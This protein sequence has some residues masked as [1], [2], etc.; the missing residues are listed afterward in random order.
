MAGEWLNWQEFQAGVAPQA[1][2]QARQEAERDSA[3]LARYNQGVSGAE[4]AATSVG[5]KPVTS[6]AAYQDAQNAYKT[7]AQE[8]MHRAVAAPGWDTGSAGTT[9]M[10]SEWGKLAGRLA[11]A[12]EN[13]DGRIAAR[14][15]A[16]DEAFKRRQAAAASPIQA[17][18]DPK[19][20]QTVAAIRNRNTN[21][22]GVDQRRRELGT[23]SLELRRRQ[24]GYYNPNSPH[25]MDDSIT[26]GG[27]GGLKYD[28]TSGTWK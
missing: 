5:G 22:Q 14:M 13:V 28:A 17:G 12:Q 24:M 11:G 4:D 6:Y 26:A 2:E 3:D 21:E 27:N 10:A 19:Y 9:P 25:Y 7:R 1:E 8:M 23:G 20:A 15:K 18:V 16:R